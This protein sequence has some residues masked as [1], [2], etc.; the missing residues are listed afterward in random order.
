MMRW[1]RFKKSVRGAR[2]ELALLCGLLLAL[3]VCLAPVRAQEGL[4][5]KLTRLH[6]VA[7]SDS[8]ADQSLKLRVR[9]RIL[10]E[11]GYQYGCF[12]GRVD[13]ALLRR[14]QRAAQAEVSA[15]GYGYPVT[16]T[17]E[18]MFFD[19]RRYDGFSLP[20]GY[21]D[22]VRVVI[23]EGKGKNWW[24]VLFPPLCLGAAGQD[25]TQAARGAGLTEDEIALIREDGTGY[26]V[27]FKLMEAW[28]S[29]RH[30]L[31]R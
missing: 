8:A 1:E 22:A 10:R 7:N 27:R 14:L 6:V 31:D 12:E 29:L 11:A 3:C 13:D 15:R 28:G 4:A 24:C 23:G 19:T 26:V 20:A 17:R 2:P 5:D 16:V 21:Y 30:W 9:D 25:I 18:K